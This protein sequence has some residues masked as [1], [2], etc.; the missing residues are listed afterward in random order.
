[1]QPAPI[2]AVSSQQQQPQPPFAQP[3]PIPAAPQ[4]VNQ[5]LMHHA[6]SVLLIINQ[7]EGQQMQMTEQQHLQY[8]DAVS[9]LSLQQFLILFV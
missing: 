1:M 5:D 6:A 3:A 7:M 9:S 8:M 4:Q 2:P